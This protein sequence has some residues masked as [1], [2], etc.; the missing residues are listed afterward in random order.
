VGPDGAV[1]HGMVGTSL[2]LEDASWTV[3]P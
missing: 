2:V 3:L 1:S